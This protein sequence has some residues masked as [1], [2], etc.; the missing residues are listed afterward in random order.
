[1][2]PNKAID[3]SPSIITR[4]FNVGLTRKKLAHMTILHEYPLSMVEHEGFIDFLNTICYMFKLILRN[5]IRFDILK[6]YKV[7]KDKL[8]QI[9]EQNKSII[10]ITIDMWTA[11]NQKRG[12][13]TVTTHFMDDPW[14]L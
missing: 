10:I 14:N 5:T 7:E 9:L 1:M 8:K 3:A 4:T 6:I 12:Y 13:M 11:N 2:N